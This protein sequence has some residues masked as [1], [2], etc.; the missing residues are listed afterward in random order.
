MKI[1]VFGDNIGYV[2]D[3]VST[4]SNTECNL[5]E[6]NRIKWVTDLASISRGKYESKNPKVRYE[7]LL[8][9]ASPTM[10]DIEVEKELEQGL[11]HNHWTI[12]KEYNDKVWWYVADDLLVK[13][14]PS[15]PLEFLPVVFKIYH[16]DERVF[17]LDPT[18]NKIVNENGRPTIG[19]LKCDITYFM[20]NIA[21]HSYISHGYLYTNMRTLINSGLN[22]EY[23]PYG[24]SPLY[25]SFKAVRIK[26]PM[27]VFGQ[28]M[29]HTMIS[30]ESQSDR[31]AES[32]EYWLPS[33][34]IEKL[35][36]YNIN[37]HK[38]QANITSSNEN[39][40]VLTADTINAILNLRMYAVSI[41][42]NETTREEVHNNLVK[43]LLHRYSQ[44]I[45]QNIFK[46]L[47]YKREIWSRAIYYFKY[48]E[49]VLTGWNNDPKVWE[50][51]FLEREV[52][53]DIHKSWVQDETR[54]VCEA[55]AK[56]LKNKKL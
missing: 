10:K 55:I 26:V 40:D 17:L 44:D 32:T 20:N 49:M 2:T 34:F 52:Y 30:K 51:L 13:G 46:F 23:I 29:T 18:V 37:H 39:H 47:E 27:F 53:P 31:V 35:I 19:T 9:E 38:I 7:Q 33:D 16:V 41:K 50:H 11:M 28:L 45:V 8:K 6:E 14:R 24:D 15:R 3:E 43:E 1:D 54:M 25:R 5:N 22:Y 42:N 48:K 21:K 12:W 56:V 4:V 36:E